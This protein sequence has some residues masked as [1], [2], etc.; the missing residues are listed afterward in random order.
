MGSNEGEQDTHLSDTAIQWLKDGIECG[1]KSLRWKGLILIVSRSRPASCPRL[2]CVS[3]E[4]GTLQW[5]NY[6]WGT[7]DFH[8]LRSGP[9]LTDVDWL[10]F[11]ISSETLTLFGARSYRMEH[12]NDNLYL[13]SVFYIEQFSLSDGAAI[14]RFSTNGWR[15]K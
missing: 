12:G 1:T 9:K 2:A 6:V 3:S 4:T 11:H 14:C 8:M 5:K 15:F 13:H 10:S 7:N